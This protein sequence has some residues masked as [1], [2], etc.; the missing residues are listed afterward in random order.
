MRR[1]NSLTA[2]M[3]ISGLSYLKSGN[4]S[5][6]VCTC[7]GSKPGLTSI[8]FQKLFT[9]SE[10]VIKSMSA[11]VSSLTIKVLRTRAKPPPLPCAP[12]LNAG[13]IFTWAAFHAGNNPKST[14][15]R[16]IVPAEKISTG[17]STPISSMRAITPAPIALNAATAEKASSTPSVP[18][19]EAMSSD[20]LSN[21]R[22]I[23]QREP[24]TA[25]RT[26]ISRSRVEARASVRLATF[27]HAM[28]RTRIAPADVTSKALLSS[29]TKSRSSE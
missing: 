4:R 26:A 24:P 2:R 12:D 3:A 8:S 1:R 16:K 27:A 21:K 29:P 19:I 23:C 6:N 14:V 18:P 5:R 9:S 10:A 7:A 28:S 25:R 15:A 11:R 13:S 20:S 22:T 17:R